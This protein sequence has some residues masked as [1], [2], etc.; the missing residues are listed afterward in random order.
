M[1]TKDAVTYKWLED[2]NIGKKFVLRLGYEKREKKKR[3]NVCAVYDHYKVMHGKT[4][5]CKS[6]GD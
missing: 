4:W 2:I 5:P 1:R 6:K 3:D